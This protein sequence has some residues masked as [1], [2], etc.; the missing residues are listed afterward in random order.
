MKD[1]KDFMKVVDNTTDGIHI[2]EGDI[3][4][5]YDEGDWDKHYA[6]AQSDKLVPMTLASSFSEVVSETRE[7]NC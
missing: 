2:V 6:F 1:I 4:Y 7:D 3:V 5:Y